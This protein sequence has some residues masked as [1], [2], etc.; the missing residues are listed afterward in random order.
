[1]SDRTFEQ[2]HVVMGY[3]GMTYRDPSF[4]AAQVFSGLFGGGMS[5]RLFQE[6]REKRGLCYSIY[7]SA[8]GLSDTGMLGVHAATGPAMIRELV[9]VISTEF[10]R[11]AETLPTEKEVQRSKAQLKTGLL[12]SLESSASRAEQMSRQLLAHDRLLTT[13]EL[14]DRVES[15]TAADV[16]DVAARIR[17]NSP[18]SIALVGAGKQGKD[19][20]KRISEGMNIGA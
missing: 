12:M 7:S 8:W 16:R 10:E 18:L 1:M 6:V 3:E 13:E 11:A 17:S 5:S 19:I 20:A 9:D 15:V 14:I 2:A 4:Y